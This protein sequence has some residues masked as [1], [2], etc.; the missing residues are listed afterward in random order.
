MSECVGLIV[1]VISFYISNIHV[2]ENHTST[3]QTDRQT[4]GRTDNI[5]WHNRALRSIER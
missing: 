1:G 3:L 2:C 4:G 5:R